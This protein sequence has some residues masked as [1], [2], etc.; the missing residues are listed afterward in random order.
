MA[1]KA[2]NKYFN[3]TSHTENKKLQEEAFFLLFNI[4]VLMIRK[5]WTKRKR[6]REVH[7]FDKFYL[8]KGQ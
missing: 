5:E 2:I 6:D 7:R 3:I 1:M 4:T 8:P